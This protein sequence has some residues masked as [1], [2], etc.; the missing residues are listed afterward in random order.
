MTNLSKQ[1]MSVLVAG[2]IDAKKYSYSP[3]SHYRV[4]C[5]LQT[6]NGQIYTGEWVVKGSFFKHI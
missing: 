2:A 3:Y 6:E 1:E 5:S 4:G